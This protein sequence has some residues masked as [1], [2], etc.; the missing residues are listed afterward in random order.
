MRGE[1]RDVDLEGLH[2]ESDEGVRDLE[3]VGLPAPDIR[4]IASSCTCVNCSW[5][6]ATAASTRRAMLAKIRPGLGSASVFSV[7]IASGVLAV[8]R[9][10]PR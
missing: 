6:V 3:P 7:E 5:V 4:E 1:Y 9:A 10:A 2:R 8:S